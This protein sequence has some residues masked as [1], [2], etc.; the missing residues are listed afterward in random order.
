M[1]TLFNRIPR[2]RPQIREQTFHRS[3]LYYSASK[4][5]ACLL[6]C[7][8]AF[9]MY[10]WFSIKFAVILYITM[11]GIKDNDKL[12]S[13]QTCLSSLDESYFLLLSMYIIKFIGTFYRMYLF[14]SRKT[15]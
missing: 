8:L 11:M 12:R 14:H 3:K 10:F 6:W 13:N 1:F 7:G 4:S 5:E 2:N 9:K 15:D